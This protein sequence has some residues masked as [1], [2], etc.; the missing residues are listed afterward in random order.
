MIIGGPGTGKS[1]VALLRAKRLSDERKPYIFLVYNHLLYQSSQQLFEGSLVSSTWI[2]W[3]CRTFQ[4]LTK[5]PPPMR[6]PDSS[7]DWKHINWKAA[8]EII[9]ETAVSNET[10]R[11]YLVIDEGQDM[12]PDFYACL[13]NLGFEN[14]FVVADQNQQI[15]EENSTIKDLQSALALNDRLSIILKKN[16]RNKYP[17]A[18]LAQAFYTGDSAAPPLD[19]P[20][21]PQNQSGI[22]I[23]CIYPDRKFDNIVQRI[24]KRA[25]RDP[26]KLLGV[27]AP[28]NDIRKKFYRAIK[29]IKQGLDNGAPNVSTYDNKDK[30][31]LTFNEGGIIVINA[32]SCK[33]LEFDTVFLADIGGFNLQHNFE[34]RAKRLFYVMVARARD[35]VFMLHRNED[36]WTVEKILPT[37]ANTLNRITLE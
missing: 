10:I 12:P 29:K 11:P 17:V 25:D 30:K 3:F 34:Q 20:R 14:F 2:G 23:L 1:V 37:D 6:P 24:A 9:D 18:K 32:Q 13:G 36:D 8:R 22:P 16:H 7:S 27:I 19:L 35:M 33:G 31:G 4:R 26:A 21:Q 15:T 5:K 28:N